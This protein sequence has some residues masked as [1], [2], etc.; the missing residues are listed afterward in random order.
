[1]A[2]ADVRPGI[3]G[4][5][6]TEAAQTPAPEGDGQLWQRLSDMVDPGQ[7]R[8]KMADDVEIKEFHLKWGNDY[9]MIANPRDLL[10]FKLEPG[11]VEIVKLMDGTRTVKEIVLE[12]FKES[13][14][15]ELSAVADL[16]KQLYTGNFL[17]RHYVDLEGEVRRAMDETTA[18][19]RR[20]RKFLRTLSIEWTGADRVVTWFYRHG[21]KYFFSRPVLILGAIIAIAG[22]PAF[23][24]IV[25]SDDYNLS[26]GSLAFGFLILIFLNYFL[27]FAHELGHA[28]V[29]T[30]NGR[31]IKSAGF[32]IYFGSPAFFVDSSDGLMIDRWQRI[33]QSFAGPYA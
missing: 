18:A 23:V 1:M 11:E 20:G 19:A 31:K 30:K 9:A 7:Y 5:L 6:E 28:V 12:R 16:V 22:L 32:M 4:R 8:P 27:T 24:A 14:D 3:W 13:G 29:M 15:L 21:L 25:N 17:D 26:G 2:V 33:S 10:H